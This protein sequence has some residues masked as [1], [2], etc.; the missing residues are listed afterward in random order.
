MDIK[1]DAKDII[2]DIKDR[3]LLSLGSVGLI[4]AGCAWAYTYVTTTFVMAADYQRDQAAY[5]AQYATQAKQQ[6]MQLNG[7]TKAVI[8]SQIYNL[9]ANP[10][11]TPQDQARLE[12]LLRQR[13]DIDRASQQGR[14]YSP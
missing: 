4:L 3:P 13:Q 12:Q 2:S 9:Q 7:V 14:P 11:R 1:Q 10:R 8:E 5:Q 6:T